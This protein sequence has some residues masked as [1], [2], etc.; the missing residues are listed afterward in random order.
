MDRRKAIGIL[1]LV[2]GLVFI[3]IL[4][5]SFVMDDFDFITNWRLIQNLKNIPRFFVGYIPPESQ[6]GIYS[7][8]RTLLFAV[9][10]FLFH[11]WASGWH[12]VSI[13]IHFLGVWAVYALTQI[14]AGHRRLAFMT[15]LIFAV[16]P[17]HVEAVTAVTGS[18]DTAGVV[19][20]LW[21]VY[22]YLRAVLPKG[23][24]SVFDGA[25]WPS[26]PGVSARV[27]RR[28][29]GLSCLLGVLAIGTHELMVSLPV[30]LMMIDLF[31]LTPDFSFRRAIYRTLPFFAAALFYVW[32][33]HVVLGS[34]ARGTYVFDQPYLT[35]LVVIKAWAQYLGV[36]FFPA[37]LTH[38]KLISPGIMSFDP[39]D[40]NRSAF[41]AQSW[42]DPQVLLSFGILAG[43][44]AAG[45][46]LYRKR[47]LLSFGIFW[48]FL[49][50]SPVA[51]MVPSA[52]YYAERYLYPGS[53]A[54]A[55]ILAW[56]GL[57]L[58]QRV[59]ANRI[60]R[61]GVAV[62][63]SL[64]VLAYAGRTIIR[65][66][67][68]KD[69]IT[70]YEKAVQLNPQS[71]YLKNDLAILLSRAGDYDAAVHYFFQALAIQPH[72]AHFYF[73]L[74]ETYASSGQDHKAQQAL[75]QA[76]VYQPD[77][78]EAYFNLAGAM[79]F[80]GKRQ[81]G[82]DYLEKALELWKDQ[83]RVLEAG[84]AMSTFFVFIAQ[85]D[86]ALPKDAAQ[87]FLKYYVQD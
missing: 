11:E 58:G 16:H 26:G 3:N 72:N 21:A 41:L 66:R 70:F 5:N 78:P 30:L 51:Q 35:I 39:E 33:K 69:W 10:Y 4:S 77:F 44:A 84:E 38:N 34:I 42:H 47:P 82:L 57:A 63:L 20:G 83:G 64:V 48:F 52:V 12:V 74:A 46:M 2:T 60:Q 23:R 50:L 8:F 32:A 62:L 81:Q 87:E 6:P 85:H 80:E 1:A 61:R 36:L 73:S 75:Q 55:M 53:W 45:L 7:P 49:S 31:F 56:A 29:Y 68:F 40:F 86:G 54:Y 15:A 71:A 17:V 28:A 37:V 14:L 13:M 19:L 43:L 27:D 65:N 18:V 67:D 59:A 22:W 25:C 76:I 79:V 9:Q 24:S